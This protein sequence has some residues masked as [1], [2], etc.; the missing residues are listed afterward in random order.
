MKLSKNCT[1]NMHNIRKIDVTYKEDIEYLKWVGLYNDTNI[2]LI[3]DGH[4]LFFTESYAFDG[5]AAVDTKN[6]QCVVIDYRSN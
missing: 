3:K 6:N 5:V 1:F 2:Q 4:L